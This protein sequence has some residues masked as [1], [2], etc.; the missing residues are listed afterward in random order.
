[1]KK[2]LNVFACYPY[3]FMI[4]TEVNN[5]LLTISLNNVPVALCSALLC[6][7][8]CS[9]HWLMNLVVVDECNHSFISRTASLSL[10]QLHYNKLSRLVCRKKNTSMLSLVKNSPRSEWA[11][12]SISSSVEVDLPSRTSG[13]S[14]IRN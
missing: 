13:N 5:F 3:P 8:T 7:K 10:Q 11:F 9:K 4:S 14:I 6:S 1:M 2:C 12:R